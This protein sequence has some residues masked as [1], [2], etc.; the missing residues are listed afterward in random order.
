MN[1]K[2]SNIQNHYRGG[3]SANFKVFDTII[4]IYY[5]FGISYHDYFVGWGKIDSL[6]IR[7]CNLHLRVSGLGAREIRSPRQNQ[8]CHS[9]FPHQLHK[10]ECPLIILCFAPPPPSRNSRPKRARVS[11]KTPC[12]AYLIEMASDCVP[13]ILLYHPFNLFLLLHTCRIF[14][15]SCAPFPV[16][17]HKSTHDYTTT[18]PV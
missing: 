1:H 15:R 11:L 2:Q 17:N 16:Q 4:V 10:N 3:Q 5:I 14:F 6:A 8:I 13:I 9:L 18:H 12:L 7:V